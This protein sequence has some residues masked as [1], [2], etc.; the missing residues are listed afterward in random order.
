MLLL[1]IKF[2][3]WLGDGQKAI[4]YANSPHRLKQPTSTEVLICI[5][6]LTNNETFNLWDTFN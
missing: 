5:Y 6:S 1:L 2:F 4:P 3:A